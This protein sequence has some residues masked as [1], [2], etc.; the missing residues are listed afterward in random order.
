[1]LCG[2]SQ[3]R[4]D[5]DAR[6]VS[7]IIALDCEIHQVLLSEGRGSEQTPGEFR[8]SQNWIGGTRPGNALFVPPLPTEVLPCLGNLE[9]FWHNQPERTPV[10]IKAALSHV[11]FETIHPFLDGNGRYATEA[12]GMRKKTQSLICL[13]SI[14]EYSQ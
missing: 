7:L 13:S 10:L 6:R 5:A 9:K 3:S 2:S 12:L 11:Q 1:L 14:F 4:F 8:R